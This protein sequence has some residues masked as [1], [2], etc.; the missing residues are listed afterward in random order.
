MGKIM[1]ICYD[2]PTCFSRILL[3]TIITRNAHIHTCMHTCIHTCITDMHYIQWIHN[4]THTHTQ[5]VIFRA[6]VCT[7]IHKDAYAQNLHTPRIYTNIYIHHPTYTTM[8]TNIITHIPYI[9]INI[10]LHEFDVLF[11]KW[12]RSV[13]GPCTHGLDPSIA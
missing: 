11:R 12:F 3:V 1:M 7:H 10:D 8:H 13:V 9:I 5:A 4:H 2:L 6:N